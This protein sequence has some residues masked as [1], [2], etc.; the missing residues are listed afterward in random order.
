MSN[1][2]M[3]VNGISKQYRLGQREKYK[4]LRDS[5]TE[6]FY[7]P[8]NL[9]RSL[10]NSKKN[11]ENT[12]PEAFWALQDV[13]FEVKQGEV[14]GIVGRNG[15]GKS[16]LLKV[17]SRITEPTS[18]F[19]DVYGRIGSLLEV[20]TGF[21]PELT[22]RENIYLNGAILG[23]RRAE[24]QRKF[25]EIVAF[26]EL[27]KFLDTPVK[28]YSSGMYTRLA[29]A[30]AVHL[31]PEILIVDEVLAVGDFDFQK[32]CLGKMKDVSKSGRTVLFVSHNTGAIRALCDRAIWLFEGQVKMDGTP[33]TVLPNYLRQD[34]Q[35]AERKWCDPATAPMFGEAV[36]LHAV[37]VVNK[38]GRPN[39]VFDVKE[40]IE[41]Q[42]DYSV[43][44]KRHCMN[45]FLFFYD[46]SGNTIF[47]SIDNLDSPWQ[48][49]PQPTG[50]YRASCII[51]ENL[52]NEGQMSVELTFC[53]RPTSPLNLAIKDVVSF[54]VI[55]DRTPGGV[56]GNWARDWYRAAVRPRL[57]WHFTK[58]N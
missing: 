49:S 7:A 32:K 16:T 38:H 12:Q 20:G 24:I 47:F 35:L 31:E 4:T 8:L 54:Q 21:H 3:H 9:A 42:I 19:A 22:G 30:V 44:E 55:D 29:F 17:L 41:I 23:M 43:L 57:Q 34:A 15:A 2:A 50:M 56:R 27:E 46:E 39:T 13:S 10:F 14:I 37:R 18:G 52:L 33:A 58:N 5:L 48:E 6:T 11:A 25:D 36:L 45:L 28:H 40:P 53:T 51:P 1:I 26:S